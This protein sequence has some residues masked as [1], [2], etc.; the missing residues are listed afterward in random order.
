M[1]LLTSKASISSSSQSSSPRLRF[2]VG[3]M[4]FPAPSSVILGCWIL[5]WLLYF[6]SNLISFG[7]AQ[8]VLDSA[9]CR[10]SDFSHAGS[11]A[12]DREGRRRSSTKS[13][14]RGIIFGCGT[15]FDVSSANTPVSS[16]LT[17]NQT[18]VHYIK[19]KVL[20]SRF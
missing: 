9:I 10:P 16:L 11:S 1:L 18:D 15:A 13:C 20:Q 2:P 5:L 4:M 3:V 6:V 14:W 12:C 7:D 17:K 8:A 19:T